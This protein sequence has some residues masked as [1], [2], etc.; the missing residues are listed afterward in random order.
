[1]TWQEINNKRL[2]FIRFGENLFSRMYGEIRK[3]FITSIK[4]LATPEDITQA[5]QDF[6]IN[7]D[8]V[9]INFERFYIKTGIAFAK[10]VQKRFSGNI[11]VKQESDW[12]TIIR[13]FIRTKTGTK[14]TK[15]ITTHYNDIVRLTKN[16]VTQGIEEGW[17]MDE[18]ARSISKAQGKLDTWK[19]LRIARTEV[20]A[21]SSEGIKVGASELPGSKIKIWISAFDSRSRPDHLEMDGVRVAM[22]EEF[23]VGGEMLEYPGDPKGSPGNIINCRCGYEIIVTPELI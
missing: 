21:A 15:T 6:T 19:A 17:G 1:M 2:P 9:R 10:D 14:I 23:I 20:V 5:A 4:N 12:E 8:I 3:A 22:N 11:E 7:E 18:I 16:A 13:E